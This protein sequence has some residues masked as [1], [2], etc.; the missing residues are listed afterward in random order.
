MVSLEKAIDLYLSTL[1]TEGKSPRYIDW[2]KTRLR[3]FTDFINE[4]N[5]EDFLFQDLTVEVGREFIRS[6]MDRDTRY[7][8]HPMH[9]QRKGK[10]SIQYIHGCGRA[11]RS[12]SSWGYEE[13]YL[14]E[15]I[16]RRLAK[17]PPASQNVSGAFD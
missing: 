12:F 11:I 4:V 3:F 1:A 13:G 2:L 7:L 17:A 15:N 10:L 5:G 14:E 8:N 16:M 9:K 6:L